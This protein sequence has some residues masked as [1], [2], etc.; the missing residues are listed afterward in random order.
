MSKNTK[1]VLIIVSIS[2]LVMLVIAGFLIYKNKGKEEIVT[3]S[4]N[5]ITNHKIETQ[6]NVLNE[7]V[8]E[9]I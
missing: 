5:S 7:I 4:G 1:D 8:Q 3:A 2:L 9:D 6:E